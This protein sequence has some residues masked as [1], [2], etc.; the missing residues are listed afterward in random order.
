[1]AVGR[2]WREEGMRTHYLKGTEFQSYK[3]KRALEMDGSDGSTMV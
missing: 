3:M 1:M 2:G